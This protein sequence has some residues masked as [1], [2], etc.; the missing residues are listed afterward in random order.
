MKIDT[1][2]GPAI[3]IDELMDS[4]VTQAYECPGVTG[5]KHNF[6]WVNSD[7]R[8]HDYECVRCRRWVT[9]IGLFP[10]YAI[11]DFD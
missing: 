5:G 1:P 9:W 8:N 2:Y 4:T 3:S 11:E 7:K 6:V 10:G